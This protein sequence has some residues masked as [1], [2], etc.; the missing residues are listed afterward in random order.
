MASSGENVATTVKIPKVMIEPTVKVAA[1]RLAR[2]AEII[3]E[4][5]EFSRSRAI[6]LRGALASGVPYMAPFAGFF[7]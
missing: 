4:K 6:T 3:L 7:F 5:T 2:R 1:M